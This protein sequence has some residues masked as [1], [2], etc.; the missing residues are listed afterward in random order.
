[1]DNFEADLDN[2]LKRG[3]QIFKI[4]F[5]QVLNNHIPAK[6]KIVHF[7]N[8]FLMTKTLEKVIYTDLE[9]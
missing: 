5:F 1:M 8:S 7:N 9:I 3:T 4:F 6:K 2:K